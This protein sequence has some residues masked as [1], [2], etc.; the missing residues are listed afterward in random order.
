[1][2]NERH[3]GKITT[4]SKK[5]RQTLTAAQHKFRST[6]DIVEI[7]LSYVNKFTTSNSS[8]S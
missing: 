3:D 7:P 2:E 6:Y 1:M 4:H 5:V 8:L